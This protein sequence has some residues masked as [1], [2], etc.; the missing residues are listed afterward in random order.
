[1]KRGG[2]RKTTFSLFRRRGKRET[3]GE[4]GRSHFGGET[5]LPKR[6]TAAPICERKDTK[7]DQGRFELP[8]RQKSRG[9]RRVAKENETSLPP[10]VEGGADFTLQGQ[11]LGS[12]H[13]SKAIRGSHLTLIAVPSS[14]DLACFH[15]HLLRILLSL[16]HHPS[17]RADRAHPKTRVEGF[18]GMPSSGRS[19]P[20]PALATQEGTPLTS[21]HTLAHT[22]AYKYIYM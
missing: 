22:H 9:N 15:A 3:R 6:S 4:E 18:S 21:L 8:K 13:S 1:M 20:P 2:P 7:D 5:P 19:L 16:V 14:S 12:L 17:F 10:T 11:L